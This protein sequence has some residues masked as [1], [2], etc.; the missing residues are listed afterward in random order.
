MDNCAMEVDVEA[1]LSHQPRLFTESGAAKFFR[2]VDVPVVIME[3]FLDWQRQ[4]ASDHAHG[5]IRFFAERQYQAFSLND[6]PL[7][8]DYRKWP[9][10]MHVV[11]TKRSLAF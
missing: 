6:R 11:F 3:W 5:V 9:T 2:V 10:S 7:G 1:H 4:N 8:P